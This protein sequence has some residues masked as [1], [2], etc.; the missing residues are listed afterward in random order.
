M[1]LH[2]SVLN[3][4]TFSIPAP[5]S[6]MPLMLRAVNSLVAR[7][8]KAE[9]YSYTLA[10]FMPESGTI[11]KIMLPSQDILRVL[12][13]RENSDCYTRLVSTQV[14]LELWQFIGFV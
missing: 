6:G 13:V 11:E 7:Y 12:G 2:Q 14:G 10:V 3:Q 4:S 9:G 1:E 8:L 5:D